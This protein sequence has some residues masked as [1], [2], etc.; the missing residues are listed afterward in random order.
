MESGTPPT[1]T[2]FNRW[3]QQR[4]PNTHGK[5]LRAGGATHLAINGY[6][7]LHITLQGRW[8]STAWETYIRETEG[9]Y[10]AIAQGT[11]L[12]SNHPRPYL[13]SHLQT[14]NPNPLKSYLA[15]RE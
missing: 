5:D 2:A 14:I 9:L 8:S 11:S 15:P 12:T 13:N 4:I 7:Q 3:L 1:T 10:L 6:N